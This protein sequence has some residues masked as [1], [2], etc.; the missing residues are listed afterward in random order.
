MTQ[1]NA[2]IKNLAERQSSGTKK[3]D[4]PD[5]RL[6]TYLIYR[7]QAEEEESAEEDLQTKYNSAD[8]DRGEGETAFTFNFDDKANL[9]DNDVED[10]NGKPDSSG[11]RDDGNDDN[12]RFQYTNDGNHLTDDDMDYGDNNQSHKE[13][14][15]NQLNILKLF[16]TQIK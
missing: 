12:M 5:N 15:S 14:N 8:R 2:V 10:N 6:I 1:L 4:R 11:E 7:N 3:K 9:D 16:L 13:D